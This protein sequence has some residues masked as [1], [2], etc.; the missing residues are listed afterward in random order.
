MDEALGMVDVH[1]QIVER[2]NA[3]ECDMFQ[4]KRDYE[5]SDTECNRLTAY[6][7]QLQRDY[8]ESDRECNRLTAYCGQLEQW[9][10]ELSETVQS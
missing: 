3:L 2:I 6:C 9:L 5:E 1:P 7:G 10:I 8:E 4:L